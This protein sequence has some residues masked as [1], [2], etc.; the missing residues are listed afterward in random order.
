MAIAVAEA[1]TQAQQREYAKRTRQLVK[2]A[3][4]LTDQQ[5]RRVVSLVADLR[6]DTAVALA[7]A[8]GFDALRLR[9]LHDNLDAAEAR[10]RNRYKTLM[11]SAQRDA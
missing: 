10:F 2:Q 8:E 11:H 7:D 5:A 4:N 9:D 3:D 1:V 6:K